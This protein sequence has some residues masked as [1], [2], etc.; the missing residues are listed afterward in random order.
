M[1]PGGAKKGPES[2]HRTPSSGDETT[3]R[4]LP[5]PQATPG[6]VTLAP[7][8][9]APASATDHERRLWD[10]TVRSFPHDWFRGSDLPLLLELVRAL[11]MADN[12]AER[13]A[14]CEDIANLKLLLELRD[15]ET[16]RAAALATKLRTPPQSRSDRHVA[17]VKG[18]RTTSARPWDRVRE[19]EQETDK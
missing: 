7:L 3:E 5:F 10:L 12:L 18:K 17:G 9:T 2:S 1:T 8:P 16:R 14:G 11:A 19:I 4:P 15:R 6:T 13:I